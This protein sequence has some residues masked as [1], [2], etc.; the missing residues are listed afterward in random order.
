MRHANVIVISALMAVP[1]GIAIYQDSKRTEADRLRELMG[2]MDDEFN[3]YASDDYDDLDSY[4]S[5]ERMAEIERELAEMR[6]LSGEGGGAYAAE[7]EPARTSLDEASIRRLIGSDTAS[8]G[9][10]LAGLFVGMR[11]TDVSSLPDSM[12]EWLEEDEGPFD[13]RVSLDYGGPDDANVVAIR[14]SFDD[15]GKAI[16]ALRDAWGSPTLSSDEH[17]V[18]LAGDSQ[19]AQARVIL[20]HSDDTNTTELAFSKSLSPEALLA[21]RDK[22][23]LGFETKPILG[24]TSAAIKAAYP[25]AMDYD[26]SLLLELPGFQGSTAAT[27]DIEINFGDAGK[28]EE[29]ELRLDYS[30]APLLESTVLG[31]LEAKYGPRAEE[32]EAYD[33]EFGKPMKVGISTGSTSM[34]LHFTK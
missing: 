25:D 20:T 14:V 23:R 2:G 12:I 31:Y 6:A 3:P 16:T 29:I 5:R 13:A 1:F 27:T 24:A 17:H 30:L 9:P 4:E 33:I 15:Y 18:W 19:D 26:D 7:E 32:T 34:T 28:A 22:K 11:V 10:A 21:P 8:P